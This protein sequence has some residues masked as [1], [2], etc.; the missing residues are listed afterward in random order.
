MSDTELGVKTRSKLT[1]PSLF[2]VIL[3]NDNYTPM[4]F[5]VEILKQVFGKGDDE[6]TN[7]MLHIHNKGRGVAGIYTYELAKQKQAETHRIAK[8]YQYPLKTILEESA[9]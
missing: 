3:L 5:V 7:I 2:K 4:D 6:A 1:P 9:I 8:L